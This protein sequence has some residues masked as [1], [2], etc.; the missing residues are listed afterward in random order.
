M[1]TKPFSVLFVAAEKDGEN[2]ILRF[3]ASNGHSYALVLSPTGV[4]QLAK[5][6]QDFNGH[7]DSVLTLTP[8]RAWTVT[9]PNG[10]QG[11]AVCTRE[12]PT[13][14]VELSEGTIPDLLTQL[15]AILSTPAPTPKRHLS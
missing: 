2:V 5:P 15:G 10:R 12:R 1:D 11:I 8:T 6:L 4:R 13:M 9:R 14:A 3:S 7:T